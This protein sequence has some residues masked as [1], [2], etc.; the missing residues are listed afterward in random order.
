MRLTRK[1][2]SLISAALAVLA[3]LAKLSPTKVDNQIVT[4]LKQLLLVL[5]TNSTV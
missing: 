2:V 3:V 5:T 4:V 1:Q